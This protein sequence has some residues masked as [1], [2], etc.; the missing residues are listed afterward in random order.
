M[1]LRAIS[2]R[3][4]HEVRSVNPECGPGQGRYAVSFW[5]YDQDLLA[6]EENKRGS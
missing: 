5:Y 4:Y 3:R 2:D 6:A 1:M